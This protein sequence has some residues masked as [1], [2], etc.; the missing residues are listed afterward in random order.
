MSS[1]SRDAQQAGLT[2]ANKTRI[3][4]VSTEQTVKASAGTLW[5]VVVANAN[6]GVQTL[7]LTDGSTAQLVI[8]VPPT[9]TLSLEFGV[10]F[11]TSIK[12]TPSHANIDA[13]FMYD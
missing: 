6:A 7:T 3:Q 13:L 11:G 10:A 5:R 8:Q 4:N 1:Q 12:C 9:T 2:A